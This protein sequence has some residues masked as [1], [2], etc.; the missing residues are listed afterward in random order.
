[1]VLRNTRLSGR[2]GK[3]GKPRVR[4]ASRTDIGR[5]RAANQD[6]FLV[7][8]ELGL[9]VVADGMGGHAAG[10]VASREAVEVIH[11]MVLG[12]RAT[13]NTL[14]LPLNVTNASA[15][16]RLMESAVQ[17]STYLVYS[18]AEFDRTKTGMGTTISACLLVGDDL[19]MAQVGDS[20]VYRVRADSVDQLTEDHTLVAWQ[21]KQGIISPEEARTSPQRNVITR[22]V[23]SRDYVQVDT[24]VVRVETGDK[25]LLCSDGLH[26]YLKK[27]DMVRIMALDIEEAATQF[28][29]LANERGGKDN[30]TAIV[31]EIL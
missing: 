27:Q 20:R 21:V 12:R 16:C 9:F 11:N 1:M 19:I 18:M 25:Y 7:D 3:A 10:E 8:E 17:N 23:G 5:K 6:A 4:A 26:G 22:A 14:A 29:A 13:F 28:I 24:S 30:I 15:I 31:L 2:M